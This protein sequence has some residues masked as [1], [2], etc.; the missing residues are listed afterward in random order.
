MYL[1]QCN[2]TNQFQDA[3]CENNEKC[4]DCLLCP[5]AGTVNDSTFYLVCLI[6]EF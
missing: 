1:V 3:V 4:Y 5:V 2:K 6:S